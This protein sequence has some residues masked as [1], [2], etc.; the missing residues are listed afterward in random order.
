MISIAEGLGGV[1]CC[2]GTAKDRD[3]TI[4]PTSYNWKL[5]R[6]GFVPNVSRLL[7][8]VLLWLH[9]LVTIETSF[10]SGCQTRIYTPETRKNTVIYFCY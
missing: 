2:R 8:D 5:S 10:A 3:K 1:V 4:R 9:M 7:Q 6:S